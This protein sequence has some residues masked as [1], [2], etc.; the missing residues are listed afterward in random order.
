[1][2]DAYVSAP[3]IVLRWAASST[4]P[5]LAD[6]LAVSVPVAVVPPR[7]ESVGTS[8]KRFVIAPKRIRWQTAPSDTYGTST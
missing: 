7:S 4:D 2:L 1:M 6:I 3:P 8:W 5:I